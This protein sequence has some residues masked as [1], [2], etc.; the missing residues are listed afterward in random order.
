MTCTARQFKRH[1][2][3]YMHSQLWRAP[4]FRLRLHSTHSLTQTHTSPGYMCR[5]S[6]DKK[7]TMQ[8]V[9]GRDGGCDSS[10]GTSSVAFYSPVAGSYFRVVNDVYMKSEHTTP[11]HN[12][13]IQ[14]Q[15]KY[16]WWWNRALT[17]CSAGRDGSVVFYFNSRQVKLVFIQFSSGLKRCC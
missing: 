17:H 4:Q 9:R 7:W 8:K 1:V 13:P 16:E 3:K 11:P 14:A 6:N 2:A 10:T 12:S 5:A 15:T